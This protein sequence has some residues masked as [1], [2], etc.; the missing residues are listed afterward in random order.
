MWW[1]LWRFGIAAVSML[2]SNDS[3]SPH[4]C[5]IAVTAV[6]PMSN[7]PA[8]QPHQRRRMQQAGRGHVVAPLAAV[9]VVSA[10][11]LARCHN[12]SGPLGRQKHCA[13]PARPGRS[14]TVVEQCVR[15]PPKWSPTGNRCSFP[16]ASRG[17][18]LPVHCCFWLATV[19]CTPH[20]I[21]CTHSLS[22]NRIGDAG[23][24]KLAEALAIN[25]SLLGFRWV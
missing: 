18:F 1:P 19:G 25:R 9:H 24:C 7:Q 21:G 23:C 3:E 16:C 8:T 11:T 20:R 15:V 6:L 14:W 10:N 5:P 17:G 12:G 4:R 2:L 22:S 13:S